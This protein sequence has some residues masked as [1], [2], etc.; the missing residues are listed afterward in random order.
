[1]VYL[2]FID[3]LRVRH[4]FQNMKVFLYRISP[5]TILIAVFINNSISS[6]GKK[7]KKKKNPFFLPVA[8]AVSSKL[9][10]KIVKIAFFNT[11]LHD[12][13][14]WYSKVAIPLV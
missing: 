3:I 11:M 4:D 5:S 14:S 12:C 8:G 7:K 9:T 2:Y 13:I 6:R 10:L 1:M